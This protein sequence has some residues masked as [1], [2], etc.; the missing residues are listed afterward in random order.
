MK[1]LINKLEA[2]RDRYEGHLEK[3]EAEIIDICDFSARL[4]WCAGDGHLVLNE[5]TTSVAP[6]SCLRNRTKYDELT[7][8]DHLDMAI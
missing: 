6:L 3:L 2:S 5:E 8:G 1:E 4:T 7:E